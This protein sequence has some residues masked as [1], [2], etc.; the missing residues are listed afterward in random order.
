MLFAHWSDELFPYPRPEDRMIAKELA[1]AGLDLLIAH[2]PHVV[3]GMEIFGSCPVF[4][5]LGNFFFSP[6]VHSSQ[7]K[8]ISP[9]PRN[10][11]GL[12]VEVTFTKKAKP[13]CRPVSFWQSGNSV[14]SDPQNRAVLQMKRTSKP[15]TKL[16]GDTYAKWYSQKRTLFEKYWAKWEFGVRQLGLAGTLKRIF[17]S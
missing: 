2:H 3:R 9:A 7:H 16:Q 4:Y 6:F 15:L 1:N 11:E 5:S 17:A 14:I 12:G 10:R 8:V 13:T